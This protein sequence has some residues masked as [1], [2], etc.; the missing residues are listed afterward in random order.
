MACVGKEAAGVCEHTNEFTERGKTCQILKLFSHTADMVVEPPCA[1]VLHGRQTAKTFRFFA[2]ILEATDERSERRVIGRVQG[3]ENRFGERAFHVER[4]EQS[5]ESL[6]AVG[7]VDGIV[8]GIGTEKIF[9]DGIG[10]AHCAEVNL[11]DPTVFYVFRAEETNH[12]A[13]VNGGHFSG[14]FFACK[15][16]LESF[17]SRS[18]CF[19]RV[20]GFVKNNGIVKAVIGGT[21]AVFFKESG[22]GRK[23][24]A[25]RINILDLHTA[26]SRKLCD[27]VAEVGLVQI[28]NAVGAESGKN[29]YV[30]GF[31]FRNDLMIFQRVDRIVC[32][33]KKLDVGLLDDLT[34]AHIVG[35]K[36]FIGKVPDR[37]AGF[38]R[39]NTFVTEITFQFQMGPMIKRITDQG[40]KRARKRFKFFIIAGI[41]RNHAFGKSAGTH[42]APFIVIGAEPDFRNIFILFIFGNFFGVHM[43]VIV[44]DGHFRSIVVVENSRRFGV[45]QKIIVHKRFHCFLP[46][47]SRF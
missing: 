45:E 40:R 24:R 21:A 19:F 29:L 4:I 7:A 46:S 8:T 33:A 9:H 32:R 41:T 34:H 35:S 26:N 30:K 6:N 25:K 2:R 15:N 20:F 22:S 31:V 3:I 37:F 23:R 44:N 5:C 36:F 14:C 17:V 38:G 16:L 12:R 47:F 39:K 1:T 11:H 10:G 28:H 43:T 13:L 42:G 18:L 27:I